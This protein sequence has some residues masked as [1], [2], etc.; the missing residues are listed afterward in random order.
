MT[1]FHAKFLSLIAI[2]CG[3]LATAKAQSPNDTTKAPVDE[4]NPL[5]DPKVTKLLDEVRTLHSKQQFF[6]ALTKLSEVEALL[7]DNPVL[8]NVRGSIYTSLRDFAHARES[9]EHA[10]RIVP[11]AIEPKFNKVE[12]LYA[13]AKYAEAEPAF[14]KLI[15]DFPKLKEDLRHLALFKI[16]VCQLKQDKVADAE[17]TMKSFTFMDDTPA[18]YYS[19]AAFAFRKNDKEEGQNWMNKAS[20]IFRADKNA[21]YIDT[22]M[23]ARWVP[24][25][26]VPDA[27]K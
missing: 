21:F 12:L 7:P 16:L 14:Q 20:N 11:D 23:E 22:L 3:L 26:Q 24:S 17:K 1:G 2:S 13:E 8:I 10:E 25:M 6:E 4:K 19:K 15:A 18:F 27:V 5:L 9:F